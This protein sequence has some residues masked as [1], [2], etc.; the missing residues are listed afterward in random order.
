MANSTRKQFRIELLPALH[1]D[2]IW[3]EYGESEAPQRIVVDGGPI[4]AYKA[5]DARVAKL[6]PGD[7][8][9]ELFAITHVDG[10][11]IEGAVRLIAD[12]NDSLVFREVWFNGWRHLEKVPGMLGP[13]QGEFVSALIERFIGDTRWNASPPFAGGPVLVPNSGKPPVATLEGGMQITLLSPT[14]AKLEKLRKAWLSD[15]NRKGFDPG[16]LDAAL[17]L[18]RSQRRLIPKGLLGGSYQL[19]NERI[20]LDSAVANGSSLAM[21]AEFDG[22]RCLLLGDAHPD[23]V[24]RSLKKL[25]ATPSHPLRLDAVKVAHH[26]S[27]GNTTPELLDLVACKRFLISTSGAVFNHPDREAVDLIIDRAGPGVELVFNYLSD[28]TLPWADPNDQ[29]SRH[30]SAVYPET[31]GV[32]IAVDLLES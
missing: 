30:Y 17:E 23:A 24:V 11:H 16:D 1:G 10:D 21:L 26:G 6:K 5:L 25:G 12:K 19:G 28:T 2:C 9:I 3:I 31:Q 29:Q 15:V 4:G 7:R 20:A 22:V 13:V 27:K 8:E 18:L 14:P 32:G